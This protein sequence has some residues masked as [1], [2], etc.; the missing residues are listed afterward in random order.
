MTV[1]NYTT[2]KSIFRLA[3]PLMLSRI[4][5]ILFF[6]I[7]AAFLGNYPG[8]GLESISTAVVF[9]LT[10]DTFADGWVTSMIQTNFSEKFALK[11]HA[12][13]KNGLF[14]SLFL[15]LPLS[16]A[17]FSIVRLILP[18]AMDYT[19]SD[20]EIRSL[21]IS[22]IKIR[23]WG[24]PFILYNYIA[25]A[26][27]I[28][29]GKTRIIPLITLLQVGVTF[30]GNYHFVFVESLG[31]KG[32]AISTVL[33]EF[34]GVIGYSIVLYYLYSKILIDTPR[35]QLHLSEIKNLLNFNYAFR[36]TF[37]ILFWYLFFAI[38]TITGQHNSAVSGVVK[39]LFSLMIFSISP[40]RNTV[41]TLLSKSIAEKK[42][43]NIYVLFK[44]VSLACFI[45]AAIT[46]FLIFVL[47]Q[48]LMG[49]YLDK[50]RVDIGADVIKCMIPLCLTIP[51]VEPFAHILIASL[52]ALKKR[53]LLLYID[54][55]V[56][57][58]YVTFAY[59]LAVLMKQPIQIIWLAEP[60]YALLNIIICYYFFKKYISTGNLQVV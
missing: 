11:N 43:Y 30:L 27:I 37:S 54:F 29:N 40:F 48:P 3:L 39:S 12:G 9:F 8:M 35:F 52:N 28:A 2:Y 14:N 45:T 31:I 6:V 57:I 32:T 7:S 49:L 42:Y 20:P 50:S 58:C 60:F 33:S 18:V 13:V 22:Y 59:V 5:E 47:L 23:C 34:T 41:I 21:T 53:A 1:S 17:L 15:I 36:N 24:I 16:L 26:L 25:V 19:I 56:S 44:R 55:G 10:I 46:S 51:F 4:P 38:I